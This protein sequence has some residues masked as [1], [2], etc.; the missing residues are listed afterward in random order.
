MK[1]AQGKGIEEQ[2][3]GNRK[4]RP[5]SIISGICPGITLTVPLLSPSSEQLSEL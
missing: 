2:N 4:A 1:E 3:D 5:F